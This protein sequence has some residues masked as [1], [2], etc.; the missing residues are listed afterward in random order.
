M[1]ASIKFLVWDTS[2]KTAALATFEADTAAGTLT[3]LAEWIVNVETSTHSE[4][5]LWAIDGILKA[6]RLALEELDFFGVGVG[7]GSFTGLRIGITTARTLAHSL[8]KPLVGVSSLSALARPVALWLQTLKQDAVLIASSDA[9]KGE[10]FALYGKPAEILSDVPISEQVLSPSDLIKAIKKK[11]SKKRKWLAVGEGRKRYLDFWKELPSSL[12]IKFPSLYRDYFQNIQGRYLG[13][14]VW[15]AYKGG[16]IQ[17]A[18]T[19]FPR[20]LRASSAELKLK[21]KQTLCRIS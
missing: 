12:E 3:L 17:N 10:L 11:L 4:R 16:K 7:P 20:Y 8:N 2:S 9:C 6:S 14:L 1:M 19:L 13:A 5:L 18:L 15:E 21:E